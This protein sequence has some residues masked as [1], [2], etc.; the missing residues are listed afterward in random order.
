MLG[1]SGVL[2]R[3]NPVDRATNK[4]G[5]CVNFGSEFLLDSQVFLRDS[6]DEE[7]ETVAPLATSRHRRPNS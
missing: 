7:E 5:S 4:R 2:R 3:T 1:S 6:E